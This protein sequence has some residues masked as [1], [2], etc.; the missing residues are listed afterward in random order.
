MSFRDPLNNNFFGV[1]GKDLLVSGVVTG[2][3]GSTFDYTADVIKL[4]LGISENPET[5]I[6]IL[7]SNPKA[8]KLEPDDFIA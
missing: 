5:D 6:K 2:L 8:K 3:D 1:E 7:K 4:T